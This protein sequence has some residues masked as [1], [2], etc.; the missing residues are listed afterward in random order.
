VHLRLGYLNLRWTSSLAGVVARKLREDGASLTPPA[1]CPADDYAD[2]THDVVDQLR[3]P[4]D[5]PG[6][7]L[8]A[9]ATGPRTLQLP[10]SDAANPLAWARLLAPLAGHFVEERGLLARLRTRTAGD[11]DG[12]LLR[13]T[14]AV[15]ARLGG[16]ASFAAEAAHSLSTA[17]DGQTPAPS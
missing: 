2:L 7:H 10:R 12:D 9:G 3:G 15:Q 16:P 13:V 6:G 14:S 5:P 4:M 8:D 1:I 11:G 17:R